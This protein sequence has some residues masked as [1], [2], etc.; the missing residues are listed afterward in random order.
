MCAELFAAV[1]TLETPE[2]YFI[3]TRLPWTKWKAK[4]T[5]PYWF[6]FGNGNSN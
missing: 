2:A 5:P 3:M 1:V 4:D 6:L